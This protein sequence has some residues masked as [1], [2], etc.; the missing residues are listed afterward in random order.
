MKYVLC[1]L[2]VLSS[3]ILIS[4]NSGRK[5]PGVQKENHAL[6]KND[7]LDTPD[8]VK[9][10][11]RKNDLIVNKLKGKVRTQTKMN[12]RVENIA[13]EYT[14]GALLSKTTVRFNTRGFRTEEDSYD[15]DGSL[16]DKWIFQYDDKDNLISTLSYLPDGSIGNKI[17]YSYDDKGNMI[18]ET[19]F[20]SGKLQYRATRKYDSKG[21]IFQYISYNPDGGIMYK[22][23]GIYTYNSRGNKAEEKSYTSYG[24][25]NILTFDNEGNRTGYSEFASDGSLLSTTVEVYDNKGNNLGYTTCKSDGSLRS[26]SVYRYDDSGER[27]EETHYKPDGS[28][29]KNTLMTYEKDKTGN[30]ITSNSYENG[31]LAWIFAY[32]FEYYE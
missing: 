8:I 1:V 5:D 18:V 21:N 11:Q 25:R 27:I 20:V 10:N 31:M 12:F 22:S 24:A 9:D 7:T 6:V 4:C 28:L 19:A 30:S 29:E 32:E 3:L 2:V 14:K 17:I 15:T 13:G 23:V 26:K 16:T